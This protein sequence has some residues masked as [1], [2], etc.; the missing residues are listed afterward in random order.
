MAI[1]LVGM[2]SFEAQPPGNTDQKVNYRILQKWKLPDILEEVSAIAWIEKDRVAC[3][4]DEEGSIFIYNLKTSQL[5]EE[6]PFGK[7]GDYEGIA[8]IKGDAYVLR[9]D[10]VIFKIRNSVVPI[11]K[12]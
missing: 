5:E 11:L 7:E 12:L 2:V 4:Q 6:I 1:G 9:S 3:V 8:T 10:G